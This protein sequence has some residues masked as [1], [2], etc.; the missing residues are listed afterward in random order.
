M[1]AA[2]ATRSPAHARP[3]AEGGG[4]L[5]G[6]A[7]LVRFML[8]RDRIRIPLWVGALTLM[9]VATAGSFSDLYPT[10]ADRQAAAE[11][12][13]TP[14][15]LAMSGPSRYLE[16]YNIGSMMGHQMIGVM[17]VLVALMSVLMVVRH[18]RAEEEAGRAELVRAGVVGRHAQMTAALVVVTATNLLLALLLAVGLGGLGLEGLTWGGSVLYGATH[19]AAGL[20][21]A[22]VAAVTVQITEHSRGASG[23]AL[24]AVG[25]AFVLRAAGDVGE[26]ALSWLSPIGWAQRTHVY[27][28]DR[29]WPL[30]LSVA[31]TAALVA[32]GIVLSTRRDVGASLRATRPGATGA[33]SA[34]AH[35]L[36]LAL[37]LHR[38][39]LVGFAAGL[40][41]L[42][43]AY[44][45]VLAEVEAMIAGVDMLEEALAEIGGATIVE[46]FVSMI[47]VFMAVISSVYGVMATLR[48][49]SEEQSGRGEPLLA[50]P[51]SRVRWAGSHL[52]VAMVGV[53]GVLLVSGLGLG[54]SG[55]IVLEDGN[56]VGSVLGAALAYVPALWVT[57]A[58]AFA[59]YGYLPRAA[60]LAW[61]VPVYGFAVGYLGQILQFPQWMSNLSPFGH[62]PQ[63]PAEELRLAPL[64]VLVAITAALLAIGFAG[65]RRRDLEMV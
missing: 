2:T 43:V 12:M 40:L 17:A 23:M 44:G 22:G 3:S 19:A 34:L 53:A 36:G 20:F 18:T 15:G 58:V 1:S 39:L 38:G 35:P 63:L 29:W 52:T 8:R 59:L 64:I 10:R 16:D 60:S 55:A 37:R 6:T 24:A 45:S 25:L 31:V 48:P 7:T 4:T 14:A 54:I 61:A 27:V 26:G 5:A 13:S 62:V 9:T 49:R 50:T 57:L 65:L 56:I 51:L 32:A 41:L 28:D 42:G 33:S 11:T 47:L 46:S 30:L 21:F